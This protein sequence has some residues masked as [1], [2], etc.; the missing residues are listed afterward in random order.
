MLDVW[1][2]VRDEYDELSD[3][4]QGCEPCLRAY[5]GFLK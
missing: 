5:K 3:E 2:N 1:Q 4:G